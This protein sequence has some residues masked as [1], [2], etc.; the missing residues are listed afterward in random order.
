MY[1]PYSPEW[2]RYRYLKESIDKYV[3]DYVENDIIVKDIV[4]IICERQETAHK[5]YLKLEDL[6]LRIRE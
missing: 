1:K 2:H 4:N 6:E 3:D 5:E